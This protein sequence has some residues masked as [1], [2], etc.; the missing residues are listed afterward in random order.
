MAR[1]VLVFDWPSPD[2]PDA[3]ARAGY[4]V[5]VHGGPGPEDYS[6]YLLADGEVVTQ[7]I[8]RP[9]ERADLVYSYRPLDELPA[10]VEQAQQLGAIAVWVQLPPEASSPAR[11]IVEAAGLSY[12]DGPYLPDAVRALADGP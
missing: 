10:I 7:R 11:V 8:G 2:V 5:V 1:T 3:L 12:V 4:D 6:A 9:P